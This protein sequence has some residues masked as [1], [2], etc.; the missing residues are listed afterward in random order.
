MTR[1]R[2]RHV[3]LDADGVLQDLPGGWYAAMEPW[4]GERSRQFLH[5]AWEEELPTLRGEGDYLPMLAA[6]LAAYGVRH[7]VEEVFAAVWHRLDLVEESFELVRRLRERGYGVHLGTNQ[8]RNRATHMRVALGYDD[9]FDVSC[10]SYDLGVA[11]PDPEFFREA[12]RR[13][14]APASAVLFV[15]DSAANVAGAR[16]AGMAAVHWDLTQGHPVLLEALAGH[17]VEV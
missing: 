10:Y 8:E 4:L 11:K 12:A 14:G 6:R 2:I 7:P 1:P 5:E 9:L 13:I 15:D 3:L 17:G 16:S